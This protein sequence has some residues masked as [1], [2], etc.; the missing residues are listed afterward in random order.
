M[1]ALLESAPYSYSIDGFIFQPLSSFTG[2]TS[3]NYTMTLRDS[4]GCTE[5]LPVTITQPAQVSVILGLLKMFLAQ[6][7]VLAEFIL[8]LKVVHLHIH[9]FGLTVQQTRI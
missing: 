4:K 2:L 5:Y 1:L 7:Q 6:E 3:G 9:M 8:R